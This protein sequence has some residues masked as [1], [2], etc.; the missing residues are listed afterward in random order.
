[1]LQ[2]LQDLVEESVI[3][4]F[5]GDTFDATKTFLGSGLTAVAG[6]S[7][8]GGAAYGVYRAGKFVANKVSNTSV[9]AQL[10]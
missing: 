8:I 6:L 1:V 9:V 10:N 2:E 5:V 3:G 4:E 7:V